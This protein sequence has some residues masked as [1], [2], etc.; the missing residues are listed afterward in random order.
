MSGTPEQRLDLAIW[1]LGRDHMLGTASTALVLTLISGEPRGERPGDWP[2]DWSDAHGHVGTWE[3]MPEWARI[4]AREMVAEAIRRV[5][6]TY[7]NQQRFDRLMTILGVV[8]T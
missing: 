8:M 4:E 5:H 3:R 2:Y 1:A 7:P 6:K